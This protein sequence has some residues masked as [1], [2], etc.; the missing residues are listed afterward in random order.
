[1]KTITLLGALFSVSSLWAQSSQPLQGT[2][3]VPSPAYPTPAAAAEAINSYGVGPGGVTIRIQPSF[4]LYLGQLKLT[5]SGSST[6]PIRFQ[7]DPAFEGE[8]TLASPVGSVVLCQGADWCT[9]ENIRIEAINV[10]AFEFKSGALRNTVR[11]CTINV[12]SADGGEYIG[13]KSGWADQHLLIE[14]NRIRVF[15][16]NSYSTEAHAKGIFFGGTGTIR[17]NV[18]SGHGPGAD[19]GIYCFGSWAKVYN[20]VVCDFDYRACHIAAGNADVFF[21]TFYFGVPGGSYVA[22]PLLGSHG[23]SGSTKWRNNIF[24]NLAGP[25]TWCLYGSPGFGTVSADHNLYWNPNG[26][27]IGTSGGTSWIGSPL[28]TAPS[29]YQFQILSGSAAHGKGVKL[30][31]IPRDLAGNLR[32]NPPDIGAYEN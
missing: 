32:G 8:V 1:M 7:K 25:G 2:I 17:R 22:W 13:V 12:T 4:A 18:L 15:A 20:N 31:G 29:A 9:F 27:Q 3:F 6:R 23:T 5:A 19:D 21:N 11:N 26:A 28:F 14:R 10:H 16:N 24:C 30:S